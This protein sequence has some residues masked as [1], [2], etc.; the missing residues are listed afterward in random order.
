[1]LA[2]G[3]APTVLV[4]RVIFIGPSST[5]AP[6]VTPISGLQFRTFQGSIL[7][8]EAARSR[9][10]LGVYS[11]NVTPPPN[12]ALKDFSIDTMVVYSQV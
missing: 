1:M 8:R 6:T 12:V 7:S 4:A 2:Q 9:Y 3:M 11:D 5:V 10:D